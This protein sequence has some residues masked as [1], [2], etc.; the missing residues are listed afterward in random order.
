MVGDIPWMLFL[1]FAALPL[2]VWLS[3]CSLVVVWRVS[4]VRRATHKISLWISGR[5]GPIPSGVN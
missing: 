1:E 2:E 5:V 3:G 4:K